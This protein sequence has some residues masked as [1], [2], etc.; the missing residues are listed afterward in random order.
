[1]ASLMFV[2]SDVCVCVCGGGYPR[3]TQVRMQHCGCQQAQRMMCLSRVV[4][5]I[6]LLL[7]CMCVSC[8]RSHLHL[9]YK[10]TRYYVQ[11]H[12]HF[13]LTLFLSVSI[14]STLFNDFPFV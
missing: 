10:H 5:F 12:C 8:P 7:L 14:C 4:L 2:N 11:K 3:D 6:R 13:E 9:F 1:V